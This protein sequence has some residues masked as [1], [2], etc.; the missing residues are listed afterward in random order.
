MREA[1]SAGIGESFL[2]FLDQPNSAPSE[3]VA[4]AIVERLKQKDCKENGWVLEGF[5]IKMQD[6]AFLKDNGITPNR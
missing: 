2:P 3:M 6:I 1:V 5:P 4:H